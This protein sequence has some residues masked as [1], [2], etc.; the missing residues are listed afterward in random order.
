VVCLI[1]SVFMF[2]GSQNLN[3]K[4][5]ID[6]INMQKTIDLTVAKDSKCSSHSKEI[7]KHCNKYIFWFTSILGIRRNKNESSKF[8]KRESKIITR[9]CH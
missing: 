5:N 3:E 8:S 2:M 6:F 7:S 4:I 9:M 1:A